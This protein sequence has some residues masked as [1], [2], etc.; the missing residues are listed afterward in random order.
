MPSGGSATSGHSAITFTSGNRSMRGKG[1]ARVDD[2]HVIAEQSTIGASAWLMCTAP[3]MTSRGDGT[4]TVRKDRPCGVSSM[5]LLAMRRRFAKASFRGSLGQI[6]GLHQPLR[7]PLATSVTTNRR[8][9]RRALC[10]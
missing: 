4:W 7:A 9:A 5:P 8:A 1:R 6:G 10:R 2:D 3:V